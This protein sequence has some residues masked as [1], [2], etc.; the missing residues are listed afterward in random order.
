MLYKNVAIE[1]KQNGVNMTKNTKIVIGVI[2]AG[3]VSVGA[4]CAAMYGPKMS[5]G[6][7]SS[8]SNA[9]GA[10]S[11]G[12]LATVNGQ[13]IKEAEVIAIMQQTGVDKATALDRKIS[14]LFL[15]Q[16]ATKAFP[17]EAQ[18]AM[19][20]MKNNVLSQIYIAKRTPAIQ[21]EVTDKEILDFYNK[22]ITDDLTHLM[23]VKIFITQDAKEA[24][25][26]Y[27]S[28]ATTKTDHSTLESIGRMQY[29]NP[30]GDHFV[31]I[32]GIPYNIG[33]VMKKLKPGEVMQPLVVR[34]GVLVAM[35]EDVKEQP[36][37][38]LD[39]VSADIK[40]FIVNQKVESEVASLRKAS[41]IELKS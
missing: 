30:Q 7:S 25:T 32:Q 28:I 41:K 18:D 40:G 22:N 23:K 15:S 31:G 19:D 1:T 21:A 34:E 36:K 14:Q 39:K 5:L 13:P 6:K 11:N 35:V 29:L 9:P 24:Q 33:Q 8:P 2:L 16:E 17:K 20:E 26:L 12:V 38:A 27:Q 3:V 10:I 37:P 4:A